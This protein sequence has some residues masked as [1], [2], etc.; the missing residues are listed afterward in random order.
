MDKL[1]KYVN[2]NGTIEMLYSTP[3]TYIAAKNAEKLQ[4]PYKFDD[5]F[6]YGTDPHGYWSGYFSSRPSLKRYVRI[7]SQT[8]NVA[9]HWEVFTG[10]NGT[11]TE[12]LVSQLRAFTYTP[13]HTQTHKIFT[14]ILTWPVLT[15][16]VCDIISGKH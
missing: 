4:W 5:E 8:L 15:V 10:G 14:F 7:N 3:S 1:I 13:T 11:S 12:R 2:A 9:R 6:P 16:Y